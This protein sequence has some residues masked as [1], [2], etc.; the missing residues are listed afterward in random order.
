MSDVQEIRSKLVTNRTD[1]DSKD[2]HSERKE[3]L[4]Q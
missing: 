4:C 2:I 1:I 3:F